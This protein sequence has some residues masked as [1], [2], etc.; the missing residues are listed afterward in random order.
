MQDSALR[1][2]L[3][4]LLRHS[5]QTVLSSLVPPGMP[6]L[7]V[8]L[9]GSTDAPRLRLAADVVSLSGLAQFHWLC[10]TQASLQNDC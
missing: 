7:A 6:A 10:N 1:R 4:G 3:L 2:S 5:T 9:P 8:G